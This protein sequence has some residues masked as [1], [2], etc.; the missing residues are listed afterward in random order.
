MF[1]NFHARTTLRRSL[2]T[3][4]IACVIHLTHEPMRVAVR[5]PIAASAS[6]T[7]TWFL[8]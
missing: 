7:A 2:A 4:R 8:L 6:A 3:K 1:C 5:V